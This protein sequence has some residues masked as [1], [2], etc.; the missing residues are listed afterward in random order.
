MDYVRNT[1]FFLDADQ[2]LIHRQPSNTKTSAKLRDPT[3]R[4]MH[5]LP[6]AAEEE[7]RKERKRGGLHELHQDR[8]Q[9][10]FVG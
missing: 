3:H 10:M 6:H 5:I 7:K 9:G 1:Q 8:N 2:N 4:V